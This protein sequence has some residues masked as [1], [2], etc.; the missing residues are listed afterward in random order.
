MS[1]APRQDHPPDRDLANFA[2]ERLGEAKKQRILQHCRQC[3]DCAERLIELTREHAPD[4]GPMKLTR[5][6]RISLWLLL[7][8]LVAA[9]AGL[10]WTLQ[11][12]AQQPTFPPGEELPLPAPDS[13]RP[14]GQSGE[15]RGEG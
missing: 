3:P 14:D 10:I 12:M 13:E 4:P 11:Q 1:Y 6:N 9:T 8:S 7:L 2:R 15:S 5:L